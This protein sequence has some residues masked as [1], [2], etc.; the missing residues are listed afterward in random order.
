[1]VRNMFVDIYQ[2]NNTS[3]IKYIYIMIDFQYDYIF[4]IDY[5]C[6]ITEIQNA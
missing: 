2:E 1:M 6:I 3:Q 4:I 5:P